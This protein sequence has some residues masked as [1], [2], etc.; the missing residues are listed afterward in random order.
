MSCPSMQPIS[1]E[2][3]AEVRTIE[4]QYGYSILDNDD[5]MLYLLGKR[6]DDVPDELNY[7]FHIYCA[8]FIS[9]MYMLVL[10]RRKGIG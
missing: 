3:F 10:K 1:T 7:D 9:R 6:C 8:T 4:T 2:M 5:I